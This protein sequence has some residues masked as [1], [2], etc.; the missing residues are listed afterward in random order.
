MSVWGY[1]DL[2]LLGIVVVIIIIIVMVSVLYEPAVLLEHYQV[3]DLLE[4]L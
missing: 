4:S 2:P 1:A 3:C